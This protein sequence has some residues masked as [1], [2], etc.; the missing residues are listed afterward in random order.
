M[1]RRSARRRHGL[2]DAAIIRLLCQR[3]QLTTGDVVDALAPER[4][5][6]VYP[7]LRRLEL[8]GHLVSFSVPGIN[9]TWWR[10]PD[11]AA[12]LPPVPRPLSRSLLELEEGAGRRV[13]P[14][15]STAGVPDDVTGPPPCVA[16]TVAG[17]NGTF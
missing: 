16:T 11:P 8:A 12:G 9:A 5:T 15:I 3:E 6:R 1:T 14:R 2:V 13:F 10:L 4:Y 7:R 17:C